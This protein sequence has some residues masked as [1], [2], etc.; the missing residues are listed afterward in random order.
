MNKF[1]CTIENFYKDHTK[2]PFHASFLINACDEVALN[3]TMQVMSGIY[4]KLD[5][6]KKN[7]NLIA[8]IELLS[9]SNSRQKHIP[10]NESIW[11]EEGFGEGKHIPAIETHYEK[12]VSNFFDALKTLKYN[13]QLKNLIHKIENPTFVF[14]YK[15]LNLFTQQELEEIMRTHFSNHPILNMSLFQKPPKHNTLDYAFLPHVVNGFYLDDIEVSVDLDESDMPLLEDVES[16]IVTKEEFLKRLA[17][18]TP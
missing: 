8:D 10:L 1:F 3:D 16:G 12:V 5:I 14:H 18:I 11:T 9:W 7:K 6:Y 13:W 2:E 17:L 4:F 15:L